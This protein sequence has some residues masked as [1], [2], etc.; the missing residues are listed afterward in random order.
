MADKLFIHKHS[1]MPYKHGCFHPPGQIQGE[2]RM[3][4]VCEWTQ[5]SI[6]PWSQQFLWRRG[7]VWTIAMTTGGV[8]SPPPIVVICLG[9]MAIDVCKSQHPEPL[10]SLP[11]QPS[12]LRFCF[13]Q[14]IYLSPASV[15]F[16]VNESLAYRN[17]PFKI[18][19]TNVPWFIYKSAQVQIIIHHSAIWGNWSLI[20]HKFKKPALYNLY[21]DGSGAVIG[22]VSCNCKKTFEK[23][24]TS[25]SSLPISIPV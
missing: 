8:T 4:Q 16:S 15:S 24:R 25:F 13:P 12:V 11:P 22:T 17:T 2:R 6:Q 23:E 9:N 3:G 14:N 20:L 21:G 1:L 5:Y 19:M 7:R 18:H 10:N